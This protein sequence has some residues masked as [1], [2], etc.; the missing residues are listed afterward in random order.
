MGQ[1]LDVLMHVIPTSNAI[2]YYVLYFKTFSVSYECMSCLHM[3]LGWIH[4]H[5][6]MLM[7]DVVGL[8]WHLCR[9]PLLVL[10]V[11]VLF[12]ILVY[13]SSRIQRFVCEIFLWSF[14]TVELNFNEQ[15][16]ENASDRSERAAQPQQ[17]P[18]Q[19]FRTPR[20]SGCVHL[21]LCS[22]LIFVAIINHFSFFLDS[23]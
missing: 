20:T 2:A 13:C 3:I 4:V 8:Y 19:W 10:G 11:L 14:H 5:V 12:A 16:N 1:F 21:K 15:V 9:C 6:G 18:T 23:T 17:R 7:L 22:D